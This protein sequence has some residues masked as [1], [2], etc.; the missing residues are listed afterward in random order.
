M[1]RPTAATEAL[2][3][4]PAKGVKQARR[5]PASG[6]QGGFSMLEVLVSIVIIVFG[7]LG[8]VGVQALAHQAELESYQRAQALILLNDMVERINANRGSAACF[9]VTDATA[10]T[11]YFGTGYSGTPN[12]TSGYINTQTKAL[13]DAGMAEWNLALKGAAETQ[14]GAQVGAMIGARGC[15]SYSAASA[16][17]TIAVA[18]QGLSDTF[19]PV[20]NCANGLYG[21]ETKRRVVWTTLKIATLS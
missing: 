21:S 17:Y 2:R 4:S 11:P 6:E 19:A 16:T 18:W 15:V 13:A 1:M 14:G 7:L 3:R 9:A 10:G 8:L 20:V 12:C 5:S